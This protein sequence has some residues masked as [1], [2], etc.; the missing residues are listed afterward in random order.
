MIRRRSRPAPVLDH[1]ALLFVQRHA[2]TPH[3][4][5]SGGAKTYATAQVNHFAKG[6]IA[7]EPSPGRVAPR[8]EG[9]EDRE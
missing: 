3:V 6:S 9:S 1:E 4:V 7:G 8:A 5:D 2:M